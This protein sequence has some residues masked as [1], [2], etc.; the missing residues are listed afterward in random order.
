[1]PVSGQDLV[2]LIENARRYPQGSP[3]RQRALHKL[4]LVVQKLPKLKKSNNP[5]YLDALSL[6][7]EWFIKNIDK[8]EYDPNSLELVERR[9]THWVNGYLGWRIRDLYTSDDKYKY[10]SLDE[11]IGD[12]EDNRIK[13]DT[14]SNEDALIPTLDGLEGYI[15]NQQKQ[16]TE[17]IGLDVELYIEK[18]PDNKLQQCHPKG[19]PKCNAQVLAQRMFLKEPPDKL[20]P[21][22]REMDIKYQTLVSFWKR[23]GLPLL[24]EIVTEL[25]YQPPKIS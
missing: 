11:P 16:K 10:D 8:F 3:K 7:W 18:D 25:G 22:A 1:M 15:E 2:Q 4:L 9:L 12:N 23:K 13:G 21:I 19:N 17:R 6:T 5:N 20:K 14:I 24:Q